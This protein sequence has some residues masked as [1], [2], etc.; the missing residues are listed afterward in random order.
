MDKTWTFNIGL[1][2][3]DG[4][5]V[6]GIAATF[7]ALDRAGFDSIEAVRIVQTHT[8]KTV[9]FTTSRLPDSFEAKAYQVCAELAQDCIAYKRDDIARHGH[10]IGP[11]SA[12]WKGF[13]TAYFFFTVDKE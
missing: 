9:V 1:N 2:R 5:G 13:D 11:R 7:A 10:L 3:N 6:N 12:G 4:K 8:E